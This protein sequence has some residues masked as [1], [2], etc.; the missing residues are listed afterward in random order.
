MVILG[1]FCLIVY[2]RRQNPY[3]NTETACIIG[4]LMGVFVII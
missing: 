2:T 1:L 4:N 3:T